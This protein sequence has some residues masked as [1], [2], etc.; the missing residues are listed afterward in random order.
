M[1]IGRGANIVVDASAFVKRSV[2]RRWPR[3]IR[4]RDAR[5]VVC[6]KL[7][8]EYARHIGKGGLS[9]IYMYILLNDLGREG[10]L[11]YKKKEELISVAPPDDED[12][13][14][15]DLA[16]TTNAI[17]ITDDKKLKEEKAPSYGLKAFYLHEF[18]RDC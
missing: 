5:M 9:P 1:N 13:H 6:G 2:C 12:A 8:G 18:L 16:K 7:M 17:I 4:E 10:R 3:L 11:I 15:I 14:V